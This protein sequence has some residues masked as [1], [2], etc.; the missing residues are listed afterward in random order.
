[1]YPAA[2]L[3]LFAQ[4]KGI[5]D[6][7]G[8]LNPGVV[9]AA[10]PLDADL[11]PGREREV[12]VR[13]AFARDGGNLAAATRRCVGVGACRQLD[14]PGVM[15][16]S[17]Q[18]TRDERHSTRGRAHL[19]QEMLAGD[20]VTGGWRSAEVHEAL[21]LCLA[22]KA[23]ASDC[24]VNVDMASYKAEF[25]YQRYRRRLRPRW[26]YA[27]GMLP[28]A[29]R[30]AQWAPG[31][32]NRVAP[33]LARLGGISTGRPLPRFVRYRPPLPSSGPGPRGDVVLWADCF[34]R[35]FDPQVVHAAVRVLSSAGFGVRLPRATGCC[36]LT[37]ITTGQLTVARLVARRTLRV[38]RAELAA[39]VPVVGLEPSCVATLRS[40]LVELLPADP[41]AAE[42]AGRVQTLAEV[43][44]ERA[45]DWQPPRR[46][47]DAVQQVHC[48][49]HAVLGH[50]ADDALLTVA[51]VRVRRTSGC[52]GLAGSF[53]YQRGHEELSAAL[54]ERS[55]AP[56]VRAAP[57][58]L[59][60]AD[61]FSC[62]LQIGQTTDRRALHLAEVLADALGECRVS[63]GKRSGCESRDQG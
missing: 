4:F 10:R 16:P 24:P 15:C 22:C 36:G 1:M 46:V 49:Q 2:V 27:L 61:G 9:V 45:P 44:H 17:F 56:A 20:L 42:L 18:V 12:P 41:A 35:A 50:A 21:D 48:H 33:L 62:R 11:R 40:D 43:L 39:G 38:L 26:H 47:R 60:L 23:C 13:L 51:G 32:A 14:G 6:P 28:L 58:A 53:G 63:R 59:V 55:V 7:H 25:L 52:C 29:A 34:T 37:W 57:D 31:A 19:L 8:V 54:A 3:G 30:V 5:F